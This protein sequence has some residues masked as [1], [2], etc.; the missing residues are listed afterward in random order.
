MT[1]QRDTSCNLTGETLVYGIVGNPVHHSLSPE[2][3]NACFRALNMNCIYVPLPTANIDDGV[4]GLK[5]LGFKGV[6]VTIPYKQDV[7][8]LVDVIDPVAAR[9]GAVNT[10]VIGGAED[11]GAKKVYGYNTDWVGANRALA[12]KITLAGSRVLLAGAGGAAKAIG[13]GLIEAG[14][15]V[16]LTNRTEEKGRQL[17]GQLGCTFVAPE[18]LAQ[19]H[20]DVLVNATSVGMVPDTDKIPVP[21]ELLGGFNV[22]MDIVYAPLETRLLREAKTAGCAVI[23]GLAMLLYQGAEQFR[24]WTGQEAPLEVMRRVLYRRFA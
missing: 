7:L 23:D 3:H 19:M 5:A 12:E 11:H 14:A 6:S 2:M 15:E 8:P 4:A 20:A 24:L 1:V 21:A 17:A 18:R 10:L 13:Y 22:V 16:M 9:I